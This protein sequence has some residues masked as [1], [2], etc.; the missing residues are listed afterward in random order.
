MPLTSILFFLFFVLIYG[1][2]LGNKRLSSHSNWHVAYFMDLNP[3]NIFFCINRFFF[4]DD[5]TGFE[6][7]YLLEVSN[8][9]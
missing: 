6:I 7:T 2:G 5:I 8:Y 3:V 9:C 4:L 1:D